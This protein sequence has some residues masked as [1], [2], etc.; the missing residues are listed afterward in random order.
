[1]FLKTK[2]WPSIYC[3]TQQFQVV[4]SLYNDT[5]SNDL[6]QWRQI[7]LVSLVRMRLLGID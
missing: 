5:L 3:A 1:M 7:G 2:F 6:V 4:P